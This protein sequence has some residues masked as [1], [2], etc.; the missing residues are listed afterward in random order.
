[1]LA[2]V[3]DEGHRHVSRTVHLQVPIRRVWVAL[4]E[5]PE[6]SAWFGAEVRV[7]ARP[8]GGVAF[9]WSDGRERRATVEEV[10][11]PRAL[12]FRW[13]PFERMPDGRPRMVPASRVEFSLRE[14]GDG[15]TLTVT[16]EVLG[17][18][19]TASTPVR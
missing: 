5:G 8:G 14:S 4:T 19:S 15:T 11:A 17:G 12:S 10:A 16:E 9:R 13:A 3:E 18:L 7:D 6:L 2:G 1:M